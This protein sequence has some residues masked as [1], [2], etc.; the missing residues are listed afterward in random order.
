M[1][2]LSTGCTYM[3]FMMKWLLQYYYRYFFLLHEFCIPRRY[4]YE[5]EIEEHSSTVVEVPQSVKKDRVCVT[6]TSKKISNDRKG[7]H[8]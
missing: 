5:Y 8:R 1:Q 4:S 2:L 6:A 7:N 3:K